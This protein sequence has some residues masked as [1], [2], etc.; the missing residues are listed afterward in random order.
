MEAFRRILV[1]T[2]FSEASARAIGVGADLACRY[3]AAL[4]L[5]H[6]FDP[7]PYALPETFALTAADQQKLT[8]EYE[9]RLAMAEQDARAAGA[10]RVE[11]LLLQGTPAAKLMEYAKTGGFD[12]IVL[13]SHSRSGW[14][15]MLL[16]SVAEKV[17]RTAPCPVLIIR[18]TKKAV[19][20][21]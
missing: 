21:T 3:E 20:P 12:L 5:A 8:A 10:P 4:T 11:T 18:P 14:A 7:V 6:V 2:D 13:A 1:P 15:E 16:G 17:S 9:R 19:R